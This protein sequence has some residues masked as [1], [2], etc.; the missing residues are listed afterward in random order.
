MRLENGVEKFDATVKYRSSLQ[1]F[2]ID[3]GKEVILVDT[4]TPADFPEQIPDEKTQIYLG[5]KITDYISA[6][7]NLGYQPEQVS[8]ILITHK[9]PDHT[10]ALKNSPMQKFLFRELKPML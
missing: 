1:N 5:E 9:H 7:K 6:L 8:K 3:T 10:G 2:V 4:G